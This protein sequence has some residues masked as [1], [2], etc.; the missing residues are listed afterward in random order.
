[1]HAGGHGRVRRGGPWA[2][3]HRRHRAWRDRCRGPH[4]LRS[5]ESAEH[6]HTRAAAQVPETC[7]LTWRRCL[8]HCRLGPQLTAAKASELAII[9]CFLVDVRHQVASGISHPWGPFVAALPESS[10]GAVHWSDE[11]VLHA[12]VCGL[13]YLIEAAQPP[14]A[15]T[16]PP[17]GLQ[18]PAARHSA[19]V[20]SPPEHWPV[21]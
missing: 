17:D 8:E 10:R 4:L 9:A 1:M 12:S 19:A 18:Q 7:L 14:A 16:V 11:E 2:G 6:P 21:A 3:G 13:H 20:C 5:A 15:L